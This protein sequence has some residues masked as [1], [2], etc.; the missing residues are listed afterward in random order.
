[1]ATIEKDLG[2]VTAYGYAVEGG[3]TGTE[4]EFE[5]LLGDIATTLNEFENF[6]VT[7]TTLSAGS[8]ATASYSNGVLALGIPKGDKGD[9]GATG[10]TPQLSIGTVS[11]LAAG[12]D[13]TATITGTTAAPVLNLG[14]PKGADGDVSAASMATTYSTSSTYAIGDYCWYSGQLYRCVTAITTAE[15]WTSGHW[16]AVKISDDV[17]KLNKAV[18]EFFV[19][20]YTP[21]NMSTDANGQI[22]LE[23]GYIG[24]ATGSTQVSSSGKYLRSQ[25]GSNGANTFLQIGNQP[26]MIVIGLDWVECTCWSYSGNT[27][28]T[29]TH[30]NTW[31]KYVRCTEPIYVPAASPDTTFCMAFRKPGASD[32][33]RTAFTDAE[34]TALKAAIKFMVATDTSLTKTDAPA[35]AKAVGDEFSKIKD[36]QRNFGVQDVCYGMG[37][38]RS[39]NSVTFTNNGDNTWTV[40]GTASAA[41]YANIFAKTSGFPEGVKAGDKL[42]INLENNGNVFVSAYK[43]VNG[44]LNTTAVFSAYTSGSFRIPSDATGLLIRLRVSSGKS[45]GVTLKVNILKGILNPQF[46]KKEKK[47]AYF[48][49]SI[50]WGRNGAGSSTDQVDQG[51]PRI[52]SDILN[53]TYNNYGESSLG[54]VHAGSSH[55][56]AYDL[57]SSTD[58]TGVDAAVLCFGVNDGFTAVGEYNSTDESTCMGQFNKVIGYLGTNYPN[59]RVIVFAPFNGSNAGSYPSYWYGTPGGSAYSRGTLSNTLK[60]ACEYYWI[61]YI[62][63]KDGPI[64]ANN[65]TIALPDGVHPSQEYYYKLGDWFAGKLMNLL[66]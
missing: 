32:S 38:N 15:S 49:D 42:Y 6:S 46:I 18:N 43:Y 21:A 28:S 48:G 2:I 23:N 33:A 17:Q 53:V 8:S 55:D 20:P 51:I 37:T 64:N 1:M 25:C 56:N 7:V 13:A 45:T 44:T 12:S 31:E 34:K 29:A 61:P 3:Y 30:S 54:W 59:M 10:A 40:T 9:T 66:G 41:T 52:A 11:T 26:L 60:Q 65:I 19:V 50:M 36:T 63:Q 35:N 58:L 47:I 22:Y 24:T 39:S 5:A 4:E 16:A 57:I 27:G 14:I 62:E